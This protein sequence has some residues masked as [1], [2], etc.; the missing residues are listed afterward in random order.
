MIARRSSRPGRLRISAGTV[1]VVTGA[2]GGIGSAVAAELGR[3][4]ATVVLADVSPAVD[5]VAEQIGAHATALRVD[6]TDRDQVAEM[7]RD[8]RERFGRIDIVH[9]NAGISSGN[10]AYTVATV[11]DGIFEKVIAV[12]LQ[13]VWNTVRATLPDVVESRGHILITSSTYAY[14]NGLANAPYAAS[15]AAVEQIGRALRAE[16]AHT[17]A[18]AGVLYPG[19]VSTPIADVAFGAD[20]LATRLVARAFPGPLRTPIEASVLAAGAVAGIEARAA[21]VQIPGRW[22]TYFALRGVL[23]PVSD[24][25]LERDRTTRRLVEKL[26]GRTPSSDTRRV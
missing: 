11:P 22:R 24:L 1:A 21:R 26:E 4:G 14:L 2:G 10:T 12:N 6:V 13:G 3:R 25:I 23:N 20:D 16:L 18:T 15:K 8:V 5:A 7:A 9:A 19:W 17:G